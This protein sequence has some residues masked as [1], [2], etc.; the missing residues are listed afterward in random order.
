MTPSRL[1]CLPSSSPPPAFPCQAL[2]RFIDKLESAHTRKMAQYQ[3]DEVVVTELQ[4][5]NFSYPVPAETFLT[6]KPA[7]ASALAPTAAGGLPPQGHHRRRR[8]SSTQHQAA[9][10]QAATAT[11]Q[12]Q[13]YKL[14]NGMS[15][16]AADGAY[17]SEEFLQGSSSSSSSGNHH[18]QLLVY[19]EL[20]AKHREQLEK[21]CACVGGGTL[22]SESLHAPA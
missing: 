9:A 13:T 2:E 22:C 15:S 12:Q 7:S 21:V 1:A 5:N 16:D 18:K 17:G 20:E 14:A 8:L 4:C 3:V 6:G 10:T 11:A 19:V